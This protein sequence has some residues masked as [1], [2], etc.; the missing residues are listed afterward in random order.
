MSQSEIEQYSNGAQFRR[1][2]LH[3]HSFGDHGS[4]D[5]SDKGMT[6]EGIVDVAIA[7][8]LEV[9]AITDHNV[10]GNVRTALKYSE[11]KNNLVVP[12]V[13]L[14]TPQGHLLVYFPTPEKL[15]L[16][17]GKLTFSADKKACHDTIPQCLKYAEDLGGFGICAHIDLE[18]GFE[19]AHP[20]YDA[21]KQDILNCK[22]LLGLEIASSANS[23]WFSHSDDDVSRKNCIAIR[24]GHLEQ[25]LDN[26]LAKVMSS[27]AHTTALLGRNAQGNRKLTRFKMES[28]T[29][30]ALRIALIDSMARVRIEDLIPASVP[31]FVGI[32]LEGG[33]LR[34]Q[35]VNFSKN[36][37]CIIGGRGAGK[38][39]LLESL[40]VASA[41]E[42]S[43]TIVDSPVW[44]DD[45]LLLYEDEVG[46]RHTLSRSKLN[47]V[48]NSDPNGPTHIA[49][50]SYGQGQTADTI[51]HCD[52]DPTILLTFLDGFVN[53]DDMLSRDDELRESLLDN[54]T[55]M[56]RLQ[57]EVNRIPEIEGRKK[58]AEAQIATLKSQKASQVVEL[59]E[60]LATERQ[61]RDQLKVNLTSLFTSINAALS[62]EG[63]KDLVLDLDETKLAVGKTEF[64]AVKKLVTELADE[65]QTLSEQLKTK[66][67]ESTNEV[68]A[69]LKVWQAK[70][71]ETQ[72]K[73][74]N[75]RRELEKQNIVLDMAFIR[76]V[77]K[78]STD[79]A[80]KL[81]ELRKSVPKL[82]AAAKER[83]ELVAS[84][85]NLRSRI[86]MT[87][88]AFATAMNENLAATVVDYNVSLR[89]QEGRLSKEFEE[90]LKDQMGWRTSAVPKAAMIAS[91]LSPFALLDAINKK[92]TAP[93]LQI[94]DATGNAIFS[95]KEADAII[96]QIGQKSAKAALERCAFEDRPEIKVTKEVLLADGTK[97]HQV[98][99]FS[100]LSLG[101]QQS[102]LLSILLFSKSTTPLIIDQPEDNLDS[103]FI[104]KT[105]VRSL[106]NIKERRQII[107][108]TH[109]ANI[110]VLGDAELIIPLRGAAEFAV[111]RD[112]GSIDTAETKEIVCTILEGSRKAF[113]RRKEVYGV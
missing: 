107:V 99:E 75:L 8:G 4:Y 91:H 65:A 23:K 110:A 48:S 106:R 72:T 83:R 15:E 6:P 112:R 20:K 100:K 59:E 11:N 93:I 85:R 62:S 97:T 101:Q 79:F 50:E 108:V 78:D 26:E 1:A 37:T 95:T 7:E 18:L 57:L 56:E 69:Q 66:V 63:L 60:K 58:I 64:E 88:Q 34:N 103:E 82:Q 43:N 98:R 104:Y 33:F 68:L 54:Q 13:E 70:E 113:V 84:R 35:I 77:T 74:E 76:K 3:I 102:I 5:V 36:L 30:D 44:P 22:N 67:A 42:V 73:I 19:K 10:I 21:F 31:H 71:Q 45:I 9:V 29:F 40:R 109:N 49:I 86:F 12:G 87:R 39:T 105:L 41:N 2:D 27:D 24:C 89:Y 53:V 38:S 90:M 47:E 94:A 92:D 25:E 16:F 32:K 96:A 46:Q 52:K 81:V 80:S 51:Q 14:S 55:E 28:L 17:Y 111:I 61:L